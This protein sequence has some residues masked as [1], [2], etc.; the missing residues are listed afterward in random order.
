MST[1][2]LR[3]LSQTPAAAGRMADFTASMRRDL[4]ALAMARGPGL[5]R[6]YWHC[7]QVALCSPHCA[8]RERLPPT[9]R[10]RLPR[11][12]SG[13]SC[14][15]AASRPHAVYCSAMQTVPQTHLRCSSADR[16]AREHKAN[17]MNVCAACASC[18]WCVAL[19]FAAGGSR[20]QATF[21]SPRF[22]QRRLWVNCWCCLSHG[23]APVVLLSHRH[24]RRAC[25]QHA[26]HHPDHTPG[27]IYPAPL[28]SNQVSDCL[29]C[30]SCV[31]RSS[32]R[33]VWGG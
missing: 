8:R 14:S 20:R 21:G 3:A 16:A 26:R 25:L 9:C 22:R 2:T 12:R 18:D 28:H 13:R 23:A 31:R 4:Y 27:R 7:G 24:R 1:L 32:L 15:T 19:S 10:R 29:Q 33:P 6:C 11:L 5:V 30:P 17:T